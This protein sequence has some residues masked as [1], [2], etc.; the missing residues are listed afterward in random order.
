MSYRQNKKKCKFNQQKSDSNSSLSNF[1]Y[2]HKTTE[3]WKTF[4]ACLVEEF[5]SNSIN[6]HIL[7]LE[8]IEPMQKKT[9]LPAIIPIPLVEPLEKRESKE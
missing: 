3:R 7:Y 8:R 1:I 9:E 6:H 4:R 5:V 2:S